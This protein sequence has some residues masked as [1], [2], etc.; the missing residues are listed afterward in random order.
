MSRFRSVVLCFGLVCVAQLS[1][2]AAAA[3]EESN[4]ADAG[5]TLQVMTFNIRFANPKD[6]EH[7]W[8]NRKEMVA[9]MVRFH[10]ADLVGMQ[11]VLKS[12]IDDLETMLP[13]YKWL[14]VGRDDGKDRG[15]F[16]P[17]FYRADRLELLEQSAFWLSETPEVP[18]SKSWDAA[19]TRVTTV[20]KFKDKRTGR[21]FHHFN[22]HFDHIGKEARRESARL[23]VNKVGE[24]AAS[25]DVVV[26]GDFNC[27][28]EHSPYKILVGD[29][30]AGDSGSGAGIE[31]GEDD[32][33]KGTSALLDARY[34]SLQP[35]HGP[36]T[37]WNGFKEPVPG[38][39]IDYI[40][41]TANFKI[42]RHGTLTDRWDNKFPSDH[43]P[44]LVEMEFTDKGDQ[45]EPDVRRLSD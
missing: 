11:E 9:S 5:S 1:S 6:G 21:E 40:F 42:H 34:R 25:E 24:L 44:V 18:G 43:Y 35:H 15:E 12:Q 36:A 39:T 27:L 37:T 38:M 23:L 32:S 13:E 41:T 17:I 20:A 14:G 30:G 8:E 19:I 45:V 7:I 16:V 26:T 3:D 10:G 33:P 4:G 28:E 22:T 29:A 2:M 31:G